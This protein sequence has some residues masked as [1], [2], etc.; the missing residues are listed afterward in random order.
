MNS[1]IRLIF[2]LFLIA[3]I[4]FSIGEIVDSIS[5]PS[6]YPFAGEV[7]GV[8]SIYSSIN[9]YILYHSVFI[10]AAIMTLFFSVRKSKKM[11]FV[12]LVFLTFILFYPVFT[13]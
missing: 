4:F 3:I 5:N 13:N 6:N 10:L 2:Y 12:L 8:Y 9:A 11:F 1:I 7:L